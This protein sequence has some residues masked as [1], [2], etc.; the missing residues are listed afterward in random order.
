MKYCL[1]LLLIFVLAFSVSGQEK[2]KIAYFFS[3][4]GY[5]VG[6]V[7]GVEGIYIITDFSTLLQWH[8]TFAEGG[9]LSRAAI[10]SLI[11]IPKVEAIRVSMEVLERTNNATSIDTIGG[12]HEESALI[13]DNNAILY[14]ES[15]DLAFE[16]DG[17][18]ITKTTFPRIPS[19][20]SW[21]EVSIS[22][23]SHATGQIKDKYYQSALQPSAKDSLS[24]QN[25][26]HNIIAGRLGIPLAKVNVD[27]SI[28]YYE[29]PLGIVG[30]NRET[31]L[32]YSLNL[33]VIRRMVKKIE[34]EE[35]KY[36]R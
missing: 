15:G 35:K 36:Q 20:S 30:F 4:N 34:E 33:S 31:Q 7:Q 1:T 22:V 10:D 14:G 19:G 24:F 23:H 29:K 5:F 27:G 17:Q 11:H 6:K 12:L 8:K 25:S 28:R 32:L 18:L 21:D 9:R 2:K 16:R 13:L 3:S 26:P